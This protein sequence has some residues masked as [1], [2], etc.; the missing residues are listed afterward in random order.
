[1]SSATPAPL[2][3]NG[4]ALQAGAA[5]GAGRPEPRPGQAEPIRGHPLG[6]GAVRVYN[7]GT[8]NRAPRGAPGPDEEPRQ[9]AGAQGEPRRRERAKRAEPERGAEPT[10]MGTGPPEPPAGAA[11]GGRRGEA[12]GQR[13]SSR[14][15]AEAHQRRAGAGGGEPKRATEQGRRP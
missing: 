4:E 14:A 12:T 6:P 15:E 10:Q 9:K 3:K 1:M 11:G 8:V 13:S 7:F 5:A 2:V